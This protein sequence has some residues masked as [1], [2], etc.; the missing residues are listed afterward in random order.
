MKDVANALKFVRGAVAK[1]DFIPELTHF[2]IKGGKVMGFNGNI[3]LCHPIDLDLDIAPKA[4]PFEKALAALPDGAPVTMDVTG[5]GRLAIRAGKFK[6]FVPCSPEVPDSYFREP[7][8]TGSPVELDILSIL[9][10]V[11]PFIAEDASRPWAQSVLFTGHSAFATNNHNLVE[12]WTPVNYPTPFILTLDAVKELLRVGKEPTGMDIDER[13][14]TFHFE[15]GAW[16]RSQLLEGGWPDVTRVFAAA[17]FSALKP[18]PDGFKADVER[19]KHF[20]EESGRIHFNGTTMRTV[21]SDGD[22]AI[23]DLDY[24]LG[25]G[26]F[27]IVPLSKAA[28][29]ATKIDLQTKPGVFVAPNMRGVIINMRG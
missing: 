20:I 29:V 3:A 16:L 7:T 21:D 26:A 5:A 11:Q 23:V 4:V 28:T 2:R 22:G 24:T 1:K 10:D 25:D 8:G 27:H 9:R 14:V 17:D 19:L 13:S 15:S 18:V 6:V 12:R